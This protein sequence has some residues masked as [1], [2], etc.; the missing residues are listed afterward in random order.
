VASRLLLES[1]CC[2]FKRVC[3][4]RALVHALCHEK[5]S[6]VVAVKAAK[7]ERKKGKE[8]RKEKKK[9]HREGGG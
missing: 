3:G 9:T 1:V 7:K 8:N 2:L 5:G 4:S 6:A